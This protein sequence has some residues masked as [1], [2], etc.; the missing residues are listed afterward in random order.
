MKLLMKVVALVLSIGI[1]ANAQ[2]ATQLIG[3]SQNL[4]PG[5]VANVA[6]HWNASE[7]RATNPF[8]PD[9]ELGGL[10]VTVN[11]IACPIQLVSP[12]Q[13]VFWMPVN[14]PLGD[15]CA[16]VNGTTGMQTV[17]IHVVDAAPSIYVGPAG[18]SGLYAPIA[19]PVP[20]VIGPN[21]LINMP[22]DGS[23][24]SVTL[25]VAGLN[26]AANLVREVVFTRINGGFRKRFPV[27]FV[28]GPGGPYSH[29]TLSFVL[30]PIPNGEYQVVVR[31]GTE[32]SEPASVV[33]RS[34][35]LPLRLFRPTWLK[36]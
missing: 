7:L 9:N 22:S 26:P 15:Y 14:A 29:E 36:N 8:A 30:S 12:E 33:V 18:V 34:D 4:T 35:G 20:R 28:K 21:G 3:G 25:F 19:M 10:T 32:L 24:V 27:F 11:G 31:V 5:C 2:T 16:I 6:G 23:F 13:L 17:A 1:Y